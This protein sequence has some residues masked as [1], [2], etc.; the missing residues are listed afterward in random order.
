[1]PRPGQSKHQARIEWNKRARQCI[2]LRA[3]SY[4]KLEI[5]RALGINSGTVS[6]IFQTLDRRVLKRLVEQHHEIRMTQWHEI[7][8]AKRECSA[9]WLKSKEP[10]RR[11]SQK[12]SGIGTGEESEGA[13]ET[14]T[15][16]I[17]RCGDVAYLAERR[18]HQREERSL[19]GLDIA[20]AEQDTAL[21]VS[22]V[23]LDLAERQKAHEAEIAAG[24]PPGPDGPPGGGAPGV[25]DGPGPV[26][27]DDPL[28]R[29]VLE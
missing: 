12:T 14:R 15:D 17:E 25:Q 19:W 6:R 18:A 9:S 8:W 20:P 11:A 26:Q 4:S 10:Q 16:V 5:A 24:S 22:A 7:Q 29:P 2:E 3:Q 21:S 1:M 28:P 27:S 13:D 23:V